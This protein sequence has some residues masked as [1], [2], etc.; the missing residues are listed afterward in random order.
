M[1]HVYIFLK[2]ICIPIQFKSLKLYKS[3]NFNLYM[4]KNELHL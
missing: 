3:Y 4:D 1:I 2:K